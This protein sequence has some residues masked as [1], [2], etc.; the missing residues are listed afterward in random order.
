MG[1]MLCVKTYKLGELFT[2]FLIKDGHLKTS[3]CFC[4]SLYLPFFP[5]VF[6]IHLYVYI[7][8]GLGIALA[9]DP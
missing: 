6:R 5:R 4:V 8:E 3:K 7:T 2:Y 1:R 9:L